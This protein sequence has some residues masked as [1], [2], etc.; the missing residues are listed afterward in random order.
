MP[1]SKPAGEFNLA[2][3]VVVCEKEEGE[4]VWHPDL[5][6]LMGEHPQDEIA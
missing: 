2:E 5:G 1:T 6:S 4:R 3:P